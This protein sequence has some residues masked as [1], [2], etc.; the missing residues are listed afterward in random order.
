LLAAAAGNSCG[1]QVAS[2]VGDAGAG[3][4]NGGSGSGTSSGGVLGGSSS[5]GGT[6][7]SSTGGSGS[8]G[9]SGGSGSSGSS[10][11]GSGSGFVDSGVGCKTDPTLHP[12]PSGT[13]FCGFGDAGSFSCM[14]GQQCCLGGKT[15]TGYA[16]EECDTFG[17]TCTNGM[18]A[19]PIECMQPEDCTTNGVAGA[20]C[21]LQGGPTTPAPV[22]GCDPGDLISHGGNAIIC[23]APT[24]PGACAAGELQVCETPMDCPTGKA[25]TPIRWKL[26]QLGVCL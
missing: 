23:E 18:G 13:I 12:A 16:P 11:G 20:A 17:S 6:V 15:G 14:T 19:I 24:S 21:C 1:G 2:G 5:S 10:G 9:G 26:Y 7:G 3:S 4:S 8:G 22:Q 25:C